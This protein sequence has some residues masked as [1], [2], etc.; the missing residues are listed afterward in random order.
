MKGFAAKRAGREGFATV[1]HS[2]RGSRSVRG[3]SPSF[4]TP[5]ERQVAGS[6]SSRGE[7]C[8]TT[9]TCLR[10]Y[11]IILQARR[12]RPCANHGLPGRPSGDRRGTSGHGL[13]S[14]LTHSAD[15][16]QL[17]GRLR[18]LVKVA[19]TQLPD[20]ASFRISTAARL[21]AISPILYNQRVVL[22]CSGAA[23]AAAVMAFCA[24]A[25]TIRLSGEVRTGET[26]SRQLRPGLMF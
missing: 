8:S 1:G 20:G 21:S 25:D 23:V 11:W 14:T 5:R 24:S 7:M 13:R 3:S 19:Q 18:V 17:D 12:V 26:Y 15:L 16:D 22:R 9:R 10:K 6:R 2:A 4:S